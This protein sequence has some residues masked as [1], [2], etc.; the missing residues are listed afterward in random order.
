[1]S[2]SIRHQTRPSLQHFPR[3]RTRLRRWSVEWNRVGT[4]AQFF[5]KTIGLI[6]DAILNYKR[7]IAR[8]CAQISLGVGALAV[9]GGTVAIVVFIMISAGGLV[10]VV[11]HSALSNAGIEAL[12]GFIS[13]YLNTRIIG[14]LTS[15]FALSATVGAGAT[16]QLGAMR[17]SEEIDALE[18][19]GIRTISFLASTRLIAGAI[20]V[21]PLYSIAVLAAYYAARIGT[22]YVFHQS[23]GVYDHYF[24]TFLHRS[25]VLWSYFQAIVIAFIVMLIHTYYGYTATGGPAGVGEATGRA[26]RASLIVLVMVSLFVSLAIYGQSGNFHLSG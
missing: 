6:W 3:T 25:D 22:T 12:Q 1:V 23:S 13:A 7:E 14:P 11:G 8:L 9:I 5:A 16:A 4:Q 2:E 21:I 10:A 19:M 17:I 24:F 15:G 20:V 18:V 26:V